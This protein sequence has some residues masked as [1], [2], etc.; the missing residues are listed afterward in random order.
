MFRIRPAKPSAAKH[1]TESVEDD[2]N[3]H[4]QSAHD[5]LSSRITKHKREGKDTKDMESRLA[6]IAKLMKKD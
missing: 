3:T 5:A 1:I 6:T 2:E 4:L